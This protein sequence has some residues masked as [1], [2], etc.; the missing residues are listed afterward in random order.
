MKIRPLIVFIGLTIFILVSSGISPGQDRGIQFSVGLVEKIK[1]SDLTW[2]GHFGGRK[3]EPHNIYILMSQGGFRAPTSANYESLIENW[4]A[5]H[6]N[7]EAIVV[8]TLDGARTNYPDSKMKWVWVVDGE[9]NLNIHLVRQ[10]GCPAWTM[11]LNDGDKAYVSQ[12]EYE[13]FV[14]KLIEADQLA[15]QEKLGI[16][17]LP[18]S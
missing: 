14:R 6:T 10:G 9:D 7:A 15:R 4:M 18:K 5:Q 11:L 16:W 1:A 8:Y 3:E 13:S 2:N 12:D 17:N